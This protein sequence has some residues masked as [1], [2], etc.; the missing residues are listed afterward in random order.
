MNKTFIYLVIIAVVVIGGF[1]LFGSDSLAPS[2]EVD[3]EAGQEEESSGAVE[4]S[5]KETSVAGDE[6]SFNP[7]SVSFE[8]GEQVRLTFRNIGQA[9]HNWT[10]AGV[11][12]KTKTIGAGQTDVVE[13]TAP[14]AG[15][16]EIFCS[17]PGHRA[18]GMAGT[19]NVE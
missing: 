2:G 7:A 8:A 13:F 6:F 12:I 17:V 11:N 15:S 18:A 5:V 3:G 14:E 10:I 16:Y 4:S 1:L 9:P 19:L